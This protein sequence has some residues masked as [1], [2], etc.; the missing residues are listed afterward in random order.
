MYQ[1]EKNIE[2]LKQN[3]SANTYINNYQNKTKIST[4]KRKLSH[5]KAKV[6]TRKKYQAVKTKTICQHNN[7]HI[8]Q[9]GK[10]NKFID[11]SVKQI[12]TINQKR[13]AKQIY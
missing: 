1:Q 8:Y 13:E 3:L 10:Q 9:S 12:K 2:L 6:S 4:S 5:S 7:I 11:Q